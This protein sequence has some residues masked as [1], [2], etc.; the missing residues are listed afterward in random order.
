MSTDYHQI[1]PEE[2]VRSSASNSFNKLLEAE[3]KACLSSHESDYANGYHPQRNIKFGTEEIP[4][5]IPRSREGYYPSM[6]NK[7]S[8][9]FS[10]NWEGLI[11]DLLLNSKNLESLKRTARRFGACFNDQELEQILDE[12][13]EEAQNINKVPLESDY[14]FLYLDAKVIDIKLPIILKIEDNFSSDNSAQKNETEQKYKVVRAIHFLVVGI[15]KEGRKSLLFA[16]YYQGN[17]NLD[18]WRRTFNNLRDRGLSRVSCIV[19]DDFSGL[20][21]LVSTLFPHAD[22]QLCT[23]HL[24]RNAYKHLS[25]NEYQDFKKSFAKIVDYDSHKE[26][27]DQMKELIQ[28]VKIT[29]SSYANYLDKK[30]NHFV[31][32][33]QYP[34]DIRPMIRSTNQVEGLNNAL[35]I[36][37]RASG[38]YFHSDRDLKLKM[39]ATHHNLVNGKWK[40]P[41]PKIKAEIPE[42]EK[43][44]REKFKDQLS[45]LK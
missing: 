36:Q 30:A 40:H 27:Y 34:K 43:I 44:F 29:N 9:N 28:R 31:L 38:G 6:L 26:A 24:L 18:C 32:F 23:V 8:R 35:E 12:S 45:E 37:I 39:K 7:Y 16:D 11:L 5:R 14:H 17:E 42:L 1:N 41:V 22:H 10:S 20:T 21:G 25:K 33:T 2:F 19:T 15:D 13:Y 4:I 3:R